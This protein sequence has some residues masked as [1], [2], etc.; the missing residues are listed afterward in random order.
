MNHKINIYIIAIALVVFSYI[1]IASAD[2]GNYFWDNV[3]YYLSRPI[4]LFLPHVEQRKT[5]YETESQ[6]SKIRVE[7]DEEGQRHLVFLPN[8][9]SQGVFDPHHPDKII[10][11]FINHAVLVLPLLGKPPKKVL[12]IGLGGGIMPMFIRRHYPKGQLDIVEIDKAIPEIAEKY[13]GFKPDAKMHVYISDGCEFINKSKNKYDIIV[14]DAYDAENIPFQFTTVEF[15]RQV[16]KHLSANGVFVANL[17]NMGKEGFI[18]AEL[19]TILHV[20]KNTFVSVCEGNT[21]YVPIASADNTLTFAALRENTIVF[22]NK[23]QFKVNFEDILKSVIDQKKL[24][25]L[26]GPSPVILRREVVRGKGKEV[27]GAKG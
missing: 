22:D 27:R 7:V 25:D 5:I 26:I 19:N 12:F 9:G 14:V 17:A 16:K 24:N 2:T 4:A 20:F 11:N 21:N 13:F 15:F 10:S 3:I 23:K 1:N 6:Y 18:S 8:K